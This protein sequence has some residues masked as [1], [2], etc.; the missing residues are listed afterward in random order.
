[1]NECA[2]FGK[3]GDNLVSFPT[4]TYRVFSITTR[5]FL[6]PGGI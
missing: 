1:M 5:H 3:F 6:T 4:L 2:A